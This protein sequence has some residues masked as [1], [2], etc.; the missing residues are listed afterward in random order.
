MKIEKSGLASVLLE[1]GE[2]NAAVLLVR[3]PLPDELDTEHDVAALL[4][5][6][7]DAHAVE[8]LIAMAVERGAENEDDG[9]RFEHIS[10]RRYADLVQQW[11]ARRPGGGP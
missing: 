3:S 7:L 4:Q 10:S 8:E 11:V 1:V 6:G 2:E 9:Q 5:L